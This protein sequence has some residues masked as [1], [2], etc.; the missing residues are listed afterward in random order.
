MFG[1]VTISCLAKEQVPY[2]VERYPRKR[3]GSTE[4]STGDWARREY[5]PASTR[6]PTSPRSGA[7]RVAQTDLNTFPNVKRWFDAIGA[8]P[9]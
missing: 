2:A 5:L 9:R 4:F 7:A 8:R 3:T 6:S 1:Q